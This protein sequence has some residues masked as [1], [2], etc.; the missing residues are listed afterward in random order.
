MDLKKLT[1]E[2]AKDVYNSNEYSLDPMTMILIMQITIELVKL[3][4]ECQE[5]ANIDDEVLT[6]QLHSYGKR[7]KKHTWD[8]KLNKTLR[9]KL[10]LFKFMILKSVYRSSIKRRC[11]EAKKEHIGNLY[12]ECQDRAE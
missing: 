2:I 6:K 7:R 4:Q 11:K 9:K 5:E 10:G 8:K 3:L 12:A 1:K